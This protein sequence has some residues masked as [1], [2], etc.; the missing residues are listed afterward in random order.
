[1]PKPKNCR[2]CRWWDLEAAKAQRGPWVDRKTRCLW[3]IF[4]PWPES[5]EDR[6]RGSFDS[7]DSP[8]GVFSHDGIPLN[9]NVMFS[10]AG[11]NCPCFEARLS[12]KKQAALEAAEERVRA[13]KRLCDAGGDGSF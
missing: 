12:P 10:N 9:V 2:H 6:R 8:L 11:T 1:M 13:A 4:G 5:W 3:R 7:F